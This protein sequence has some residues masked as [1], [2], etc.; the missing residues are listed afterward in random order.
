M[1]L[2]VKFMQQYWAARHKAGLPVTLTRR[3]IFILPT[4]AGLVF[5]LFLLAMLVAAINYTNNLA[6]LLTF[7]LGS[8]AILSAIHAYAN[9]A[10]V[11][12]LHGHLDPVFCGQNAPLTLTLH[13]GKGQRH[14]LVLSQAKRSVQI[15]WGQEEQHQVMLPIPTLRRGYFALGPI[16]VHT[17]YPLG[18]FRAW[19]PLILPLQGLAYPASLP[20]RVHDWEHLGGYGSDH[21]THKAAGEE[22]VG[23]RPYRPEDGPG[24]VYWKAS[25]RGSGLQAK[26]YHQ[27][28]GNR[29]VVLD[30]DQ[31]QAHD[32]EQRISRMAGLVLEAEKKGV[33]YGLRLPGQSVAPSSGLAHVHNCL[34][35]LAL[36]PEET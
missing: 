13:N 29:T 27:Q 20:P 11:V 33:A 12:I 22:F 25:A 17:R 5:G 35:A 31:V 26:E 30:W 7:L 28:Q 24:R 10:G 34:K 6:F 3:R 32:Y 4:K 19:S 1:T 36:M 14:A 21:D 9:L 2:F 16:Q 18:L 8:L 23:L 15:Q